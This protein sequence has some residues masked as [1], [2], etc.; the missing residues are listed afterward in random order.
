MELKDYKDV[1]VFI[2]QRDGKIQPVAL[3]LL[4]KARDLAESL[5]EKVV[6]IFPGYGIKDQSQSLIEYGADKVICIDALELKD[7]LLQRLDHL[8]LPRF[9]RPK[10]YQRQ[11][12]VLG[13]A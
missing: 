7:Y 11:Y 4:G 13:F 10:L 9:R 8:F 3:E 12:Q 5:G 1:Y 2:E 6:A